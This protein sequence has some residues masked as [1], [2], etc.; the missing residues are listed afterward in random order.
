MPKPWEKMSVEEKLD[1]LHRRFE[2]FIAHSEKNVMRANAAT[3]ALAG[4]LN[5]LGE[6]MREVERKSR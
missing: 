1:E 3:K 6:R 5:A 2:D 4:Q